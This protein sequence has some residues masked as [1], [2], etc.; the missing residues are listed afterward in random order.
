MLKKSVKKKREREG[1]VIVIDR[2]RMTLGHS[3]ERS[4]AEQTGH[5]VMTLF[6]RLSFRI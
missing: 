5:L 2:G 1:I 6:S 3:S 4:W